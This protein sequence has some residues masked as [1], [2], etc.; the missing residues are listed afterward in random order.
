MPEAEAPSAEADRALVGSKCPP[1]QQVSCILAQERLHA[2]ADLPSHLGP[3]RQTPLLR[4]WDHLDRLSEI[5]VLVVTEPL[6]FR[7]LRDALSHNIRGA[8]VLHFPRAT[9]VTI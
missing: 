7:V 3:R 2:P 9:F 8:V 6:P 1:R 5:N 4:Q